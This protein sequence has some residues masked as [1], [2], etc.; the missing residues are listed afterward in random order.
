[1][2]ELRIH[3]ADNVVVDIESGHKYALADIAEGENQVNFGCYLLSQY[4]LR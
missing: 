2:K 3:P 4:Y 1:M